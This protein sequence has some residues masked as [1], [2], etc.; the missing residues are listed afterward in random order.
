MKRSLLL[1]ILIPSLAHFPVIQNSLTTGAV[2]AGMY[3][4]PDW[5]SRVNAAAATL[6]RG[7]TVE[8]PDS[9]AGPAHTI[10]VIPSGVSLQFMG[11]ATFGFCEIR[12]GKFSKLY[13]RGALL[14]MTTPECGGIRQENHADLQSTDKFLIQGL[15]IDCAQQPGTT[16]IFIGA[17]H[18]QAALR[19]VTVS[20]CTTG[21]WLEGAQF[22]E[23]ANVSLYHN[24]TGMK[25][26]STPSGGGGNSNT[27]Y[28]LK[29]VGNAV[30]VLVA[31]SGAFGMGPNYFINPSLLSNSVAAMAVFGN[32]IPS[33][34]HW[35]GGA[36]EVN[37]SGSEVIRIDGRLIKRSTIYA[38]LARITL[39]EVEIEEAKITPVI[40]AENSS[41]I[42]LNNVSGYGR[43]D[44][45][46]V[47]ADR[48]SSTSL[49]G[50]LEVL[51]TIEN[52]ASYPTLLATSGYVRMFGAPSRFPESSLGAGQESNSL[53]LRPLDFHGAL[54]TPEGRDQA[55][56]T[57]ITVRHAPEPGSQENNRISFGTV[58]GPAV[59]TPVLA[60]VLVKSNVDCLYSL[61]AYA[62]GYTR[63]R[64]PL[65]ANQWTRVVILQGKSTGKKFMLIGWPEDARGPTISFAGLQVM[66]TPS[67]VEENQKPLD[68]VSG[69][70]NSN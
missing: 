24:E 12:L 15:R 46:L 29:A 45:T 1:S 63:S 22:G 33:E 20:N 18:A 36:P 49:Q 61:A 6:E 32:K 65:T 40:R 62:D 42:T 59:G 13:S 51:G 11:G 14:R 4:G 58:A 38:N 54:V 28:G 23:Y 16:G 21:I 39:T 31:D 60:T 66:A 17:T 44:G 70:T 53:I 10:G 55:Y 27:F 52:V 26:Y 68:L 5:I 64:V 19:D 25:L 30:G 3:S 56:G 69:G 37:G 9:L 43:W 34:I 57:L 67:G 47:S 50:R 48:S 2:N 41:A 8:V 7:G 35:Y